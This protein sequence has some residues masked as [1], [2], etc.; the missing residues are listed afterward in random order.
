MTVEL[1]AIRARLVRAAPDDLDAALPLL[2]GVRAELRQGRVAPPQALRLRAEL[3]RF[4]QLL[5]SA[6][7]FYSGWQRQSGTLAGYSR[8]GGPAAA[9]RAPRVYLEA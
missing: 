9:A 8:A 6:Q 5:D 4:E 3:R 7:T 1:A 2:D